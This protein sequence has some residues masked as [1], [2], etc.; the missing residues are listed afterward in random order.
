[1]I[2]FSLVKLQVTKSRDVDP[3]IFETQ[4]LNEEL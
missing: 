2:C 4:N 1:M 3:H